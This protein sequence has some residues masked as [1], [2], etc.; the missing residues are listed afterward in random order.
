MLREISLKLWRNRTIR[1]DSHEEFSNN[2]RVAYS[3]DSYRHRGDWIRSKAREVKC[4]ILMC[5]LEHINAICLHRRNLWRVLLAMSFL[6]EPL[7]RGPKTR[8]WYCL[9]LTCSCCLRD[10]RRSG[11]W[12]RRARRHSWTSPWEMGG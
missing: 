2:Q 9:K 5:K 11:R 7:L 6:E 1:M 4:E 8:W 3:F 12:R 10:N